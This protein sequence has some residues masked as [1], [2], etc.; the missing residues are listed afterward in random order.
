[1]RD[2]C[3]VQVK[4][5][6]CK[7]M[8]PM[9]YARF[10][11]VTYAGNAAG[12]YDFRRNLS[13]VS[14]RFTSAFSERS[15]PTAP[16]E[17][18]LLT[19]RSTKQTLA[20]GSRTADL[21]RTADIYIMSNVDL[22]TALLPT[23]KLPAGAARYLLRR[24]SLGLSADIRSIAACASNVT[25]AP[26]GTAHKRHSTPNSNAALATRF[27]DIRRSSNFN[28]TSASQMRTLLP[29]RP[30]LPTVASAKQN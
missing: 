24:R 6:C 23:Q 27:P 14:A 26:T 22:L 5:G 4:G 9:G 3:F 8:P 30:S 11:V 12:R 7:H 1:M 25:P 29:S 21:S 18:F 17:P 10:C 13:N 2:S 15:C 19:E 20:L 28:D 16:M